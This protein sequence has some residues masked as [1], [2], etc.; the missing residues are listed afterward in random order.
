MYRDFIKR[1]FPHNEKLGLFVAPKLPATKLGRIL[2][3]ETRVQQPGEVA[4]MHLDSG[5]FGS[6]YVLLTDNKI[7]W[8]DGSL[9]LANVRSARADGRRVEISISS[10]G[11]ASVARIKM[12]SDEVASAFAKILDDIAFFD[13]ESANQLDSSRKDYSEFEGQAI[14]W[15]LLRDEV[16]KTID[17]LYERFQD[18][19]LS[20]IEYEE[21]KSQLLA[22]L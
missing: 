1:K 11:S 18:G 8:P 17:L 22:R 5:L 15:L 19:K 4:A 12:G 2:M 7:F 16:M 13:P 14:D 10:L 6:T 20:L 21:K 9:D 3:K